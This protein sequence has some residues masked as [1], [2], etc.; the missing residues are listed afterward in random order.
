MLAAPGVRAQS[1]DEVAELK[2]E[3]AAK[4]A[5]LERQREELARQQA[6]LER[7]AAE[8]AALA[9]R[10]EKAVGGPGA[11]SSEA[12]VQA[13]APPQPQ[14]EPDLRDAV[15]DLN[16]GAVAAG[17]FPGSILIPGTR[18]VSLEVGGFVKTVAIAD[19][20]LEGAGPIFLPALIGAG[21]P[22]TEGNTSF[23]ASLSRLLLDA[24]APTP[25]GSV[26]GYI[27]VDLNG[28]NNGSLGI[29][30]RHAYGSWR[31]G[32]GTLTAGHT[33]STAMDLG[34]LPEGLTEPTV[35][36][37]IFQRQAQLRWSQ[38]ISEHFRF[39]VALEDGTSSDT[40]ISGPW[41]ASTRLPDL[42]AAT[43]WDWGSAGHLRL[44]GLLREIRATD[45]SG[46]SAS[47]TAWGVSLG[48]HIGVGKTDKLAFGVSTGDGGGRYLLGVP[49][50]AA[51]FL[52]VD[53]EIVLQRAAGA[54]AT[55]RHVW[56]PKLRSTVAFGEA[57]VEDA[58]WQA[59]DAFDSS[60]LGLVN[61]MWSPLHYVTFGA[62]FQYG[63][64]ET[65]DGGSRDNQ[66]VIFG[67]QIF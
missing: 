31:R 26:R 38:G 52:D 43:G 21:R 42:I 16:A 55:Y 57:W 51:G 25:N 14:P 5:Q 50:G 46:R 33:W 49:P 28:A 63:K 35:S 30:L 40:T 15:G 41:R 7:Q 44:T 32:R 62:E 53:G 64:R 36:G 2:R 27:E 47:A 20:D 6:E 58:S 34:V 23:D 8:L 1:S 65:K 4:Q 9:A 13:Q 19:S 18:Q 12:A 17:E 48:S 54:F 61:L 10:L 66:R 37:A 60:T 29:Q 24:R 39:D 3:L 59:P 67:V 56:T 45:E 11:E 22:D